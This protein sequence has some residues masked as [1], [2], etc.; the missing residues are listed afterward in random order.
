L[1]KTLSILLIVG[2]IVSLG[3]LSGLVMAQEIIIGATGNTPDITM[4]PGTGTD[5][6]ELRLNDGTGTF[7]IFDVKNGRSLL[8]IDPTT[9]NTAV[10]D[11]TT[12]IQDFTIDCDAGECNIQTRAN[13]GDAKNV[14]RSLA[15]GFPTFQL[16]DDATSVGTLNVQILLRD[17]GFLV[18]QIPP[19]NVLFTIDLKGAGT[20][21]T[22][23][24]GD[25]LDETGTCVFGPSC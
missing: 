25:V 9:Q 2:G 21:D 10:G 19:S 4:K 24:F 22:K 12:A 5:E 6:I 7:Q 8:L 17:D 3:F 14:V 20:G 16:R 18:V 23:F 11:A 13:N 15:G 1:E